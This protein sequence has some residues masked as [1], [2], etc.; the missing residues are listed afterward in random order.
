M[1][2]EHEGYEPTRSAFG[3]HKIENIPDVD[4]RARDALKEL[5]L[6]EAEQVIAVASLDE[7]RDYLA[8]AVGGQKRLDAL[9]KALRSEIPVAVAASVESPTMTSFALGALP[10][11]PDVENEIAK[12]ALAMPMEAAAVALPASINHAKQMSPIKNQGSRG[13][14][15]AQTLTAV[16]EF[17]RKVSGDPQDFSEQ[18]L[19]HETKQID[20]SPNSCGTWQVKAATVLSSLGQCR[21]MVWTYNPMPPCNDNGVEPANART[22]AA[23]FRLQT[24]I[25]NSRDV[26]A[27]KSALAG[28]S[29]LG[30]SIP[31]YDSWFRSPYTKQTGRINTRIGNE[32]SVGGH[33]MCL[34][35][36]EDDASTPGGGF[37]VLRNS[38]GTSWG[39]QCPY[40]AGNGTIPYAYIAN[41]C[42]E[43]VT[44]APPRPAPRPEP[45]PT[46]RPRPRR[47][48]W[49]PFGEEGTDDHD[50]G[51]ERPAIV[52]ETGGKY[53]IIIR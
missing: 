36:Y 51:G 48:H 17:Y 19:Y 47:W 21:E 52:I 50:A 38:W 43:A 20:G 28:G 14:C 34:I 53:D 46:P 41:D 27:I 32:P 45:R 4:E 1:A 18:F 22:D 13:T 33:A 26:N 37:F 10:P 35:G 44:T 49:W 15:V 40:G 30:F 9:L 23:A 3:G 5:G 29:V 25:L 6:D 31:V 8:D 24:V 12:Y 2:D 11:T 16:H 7:A 39:A 42:W